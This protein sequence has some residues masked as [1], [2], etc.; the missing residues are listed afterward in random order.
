MNEAVDV[1]TMVENIIEAHPL[2][3]VIIGGDFNT[4]LNG[5][6]PFDQLW[7]ELMEKHNLDCT[8]N[9]VNGNISYT[10][11]HES[12]GHKKWNDHFLVSHQLVLGAKTSGH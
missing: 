1:V 5:A 11:H 7:I 2:H 12:L 4:E 3:H 8:D 10:Y 6:S 9:L